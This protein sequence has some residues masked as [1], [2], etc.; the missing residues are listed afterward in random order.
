MLSFLV[1]PHGLCA[2]TW[3]LTEGS[4]LPSVAVVEEVT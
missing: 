1:L 3:A 2:M 4:V